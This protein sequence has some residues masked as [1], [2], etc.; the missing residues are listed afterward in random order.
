MEHKRTRIRKLFY[1]VLMRSV[2]H[3]YTCYYKALTD[4]SVELF[5]CLWLRRLYDMVSFNRPFCVCVKTRWVFSNCFVGFFFS[6]EKYNIPLR[7]HNHNSFVVE[8]LNTS[9]WPRSIL[10]KPKSMSYVLNAFMLQFSEC[11]WAYYNTV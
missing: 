5:I 6:K 10:L 4:K 11:V 3:V 8:R 7:A 9:A 2:S 1:S